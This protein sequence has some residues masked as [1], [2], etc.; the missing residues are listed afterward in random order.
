MKPRLAILD[1]YAGHPNQGMRCII[2]IVRRYEH[3]LD[4]KIFDV[5]LKHELPKLEDYDIYISSGGPGNPLETEDSW[6][7]NFYDLLDQ[8][9]A[10]NQ[11]HKLRKRIF[12]ICHSFQM[13]CAHFGLGEITK[14]QGMSFGLY[15]CHK[16]AE[17]RRDPAL[18]DL[19]DP[20][21]IID[22]RY[23]QVVQPSKVQFKNM[24][25][26][27]LSL[28]KI[29]DQVSYERAIMA[30]RFSEDMVG[31]QFHPEADPLSF[32]ENLRD[33]VKREEVV[34][35]KGK[36][37]FRDMLEGLMDD[38][39]ALKTRDEVIPNFLES[40]LD[41]IESVRNNQAAHHYQ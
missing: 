19:H 27:I 33:P 21:Y 26:K 12:F 34:K 40:A 20:Y 9:W 28:E 13:A 8:A 32:I 6:G 10:W 18:K 30:I 3:L 41:H 15:P 38:N 36:R 4:W 31:T 14:R 35:I 2:E 5:R 7:P 37:K 23:Y 22:S 25:A 39:K 29:R 16:T 1:M 17:G 11:T 24:G